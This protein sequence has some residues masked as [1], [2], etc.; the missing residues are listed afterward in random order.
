[1]QDGDVDFSGEQ[2]V[3]AEIPSDPL[4]D[5]TPAAALPEGVA[6]GQLGGDNPSEELPAPPPGEFLE[7][8][9]AV[10]PVEGELPGEAEALAAAAE[11]EPAPPAAE[12]SADPAPPVAA[13]P[14]PAP[15]F[16]SP[17]P[18]AEPEP[19]PTPPPAPAAA[20]PVPAPSA[21]PPAAA[22]PPAEPKPKK[23]KKPKKTKAKKEEATQRATTRE[24]VIFYEIEGGWAIGAVVTARSVKRA[25][26]DAF[27]EL[28]KKTG[29]KKFSNVAAVPGNHWNPEP[30]SGETE[31]RSVIKVG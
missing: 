19:A 1:M 15:A 27:P 24:Y 9:E 14:E 12:P 5:D 7:D 25:L 6:E 28:E 31:Q 23:Q 26:E 17:P 11:A 8:P 4:A 10:E 22:E 3:F 2:D 21:E 13:E 18:A 30:L 20:E 16:E 29:Q